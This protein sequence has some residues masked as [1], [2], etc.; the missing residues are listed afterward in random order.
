MK[1]VMLAA[2]LLVSASGLFGQFPISIRIGPPPQP[3]IIRVQPQSPGAG[4]EWLDGY[5]YPNGNRYK[6]H[7]GYWTRPLCRGQLGEPQV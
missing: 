6:W 3:R 7:D 5:W 1:K 4:Y 2:L